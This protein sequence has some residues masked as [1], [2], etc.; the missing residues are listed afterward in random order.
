MVR[1]EIR[2]RIASDVINPVQRES[3]DAAINFGSRFC[4]SC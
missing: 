2:G 1:W 3:D 4:N